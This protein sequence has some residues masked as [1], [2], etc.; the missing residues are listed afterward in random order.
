MLLHIDFSKNYTCKYNTEIQSVHFGASNMQ[1]LHTG[2]LYTATKVVPFATLSESMRHDPSAIWAH[3][4]PI[5]EDAHKT[6]PQI[7]SACFLSDGPVT[8]CKSKANFYLL[9]SLPFQ[10]GIKYP[11]WSFLEAGHG[12]GA[13]GG[14]GG[15]FKC[16]ADRLPME[17]ISQHRHY[18]YCTG[19]R[20]YCQ[21]LE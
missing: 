6:N 19:N 12:K 18:V 11:N 15:I 17:E 7:D 21:A 16:T 14:V 3:L 4:K 20:E 2:M 13:A 9:S 8:Q 10:W 1:T 5:V